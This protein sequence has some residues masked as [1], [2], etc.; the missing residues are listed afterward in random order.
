MLINFYSLI[1]SCLYLKDALVEIRAYSELVLALYVVSLPGYPL[2]GMH[3]VI[4][5]GEFVAVVEIVTA[6]GYV[7]DTSCILVSLYNKI[8]VVIVRPYNIWNLGVCLD[9]EFYRSGGLI[10]SKVIA[11]YIVSVMECMV[12]EVTR[13]FTSQV[14]RFQGP[15]GIKSNW[16]KAS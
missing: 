16:Q 7:I 14:S 15:G 1:L 6:V 13:G 12:Y 10:V 2:S 5:R 9:A 11:F 4:Y 3:K 8:I